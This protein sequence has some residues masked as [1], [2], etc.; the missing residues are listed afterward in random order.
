M[1]AMVLDGI[2]HKTYE[3]GLLGNVP[4]SLKSQVRYNYMFWTASPVSRVHINTS[5]PK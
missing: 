3:I 5:C 4:Q 1:W 2:F